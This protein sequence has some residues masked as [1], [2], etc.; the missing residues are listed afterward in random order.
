MKKKLIALGVILLIAVGAIGLLKKRKSALA[1]A[2]TPAVLPVVVDAVTLQPR[3]VTLTLPAMGVVSSDLSTTLS[4]RISG[5]V[6]RVFKRE[7]DAVKKGDPLVQIDA[8]DLKAQ[9]ES[10]RL[11]R[12]SLDFDIA[13]RQENLRALDTALKNAIASHARTK[14]LLDVKGASVEQYDTEE[15]AIAQIKA[16][17]QSV[18]SGIA[19]LRSNI[20]E[21][22]QNEKEIDTQL[23]YTE[24]VSPIDGTL[25]ARM[26]SAGDLAVPG[27]PLLKISA[28]DGLYLDVSLPTSIDAKSILLGG[29]LFPLAPKNQA[30]ASGLREYRASLPLGTSLVEGQ[31][32]NVSLVLY[33]GDGI[34]LPDDVLLTTEGQ[35]SV[36]VYENGKAIKTPVTVLRRGSEGVM[37]RQGLAGKTLL[38]AKPDILLRATTGVP[39]R[40]H[41]HLNANA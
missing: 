26:V 30:G 28:T 25:S 1:K 10:L 9:K 18:E 20:D 11:K 6:L 21:L 23:S 2:A 4:T 3:K 13:A 34:L 38:L 8:R 35:T 12:Q 36:L 40:I 32:L 37:V 7:G 19:M 14:E 5:R 29:K 22:L 27:K 41:A 15:T 39:V 17:K 33:S 24:I 31:Y 16:Q